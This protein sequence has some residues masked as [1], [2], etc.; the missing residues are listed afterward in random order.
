MNKSGS[1]A[2]RLPWAR[3]GIAIVALAAGL[4]IWLVESPVLGEAMLRAML[5]GLLWSL[6]LTSAVLAARQ[7]WRIR[8]RRS[9]LG[10]PID[11]PRLSGLAS[12]YFDSHGLQREAR[13]RPWSEAA[14]IIVLKG[15]R[16]YLVHAGLWRT[17]RV[18][19]AEVRRLAH[20][21]ARKHAAGGMLL[22]AGDVFTVAAQELARQR[23]ILLLHPAQFHS[24][25]QTAAGAP[26]RTSRAVHLRR[27]PAA[28]PH[29]TRAGLAMPAV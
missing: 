21:V 20:E 4:A 1:K 22:C 29:D 8:Q 5:A 9:R 14:D 27:R 17:G 23:G 12:R 19:E 16:R 13:D 24:L 6:S 2:R 7:I 18:G 25:S 10:A 3:T 28:R 26:A 15:A 11:W